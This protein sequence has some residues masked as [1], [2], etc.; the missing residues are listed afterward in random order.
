M[1][2]TLFPRNGAKDVYARNYF[3]TTKKQ[4]NIISNIQSNKT[5]FLGFLKG[6]FWLWRLVTKGNT[7][8]IQIG[9]KSQVKKNRDA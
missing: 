2:S 8:I 6:F 1:A 7:F 4:A 3:Q 9:T 5:R